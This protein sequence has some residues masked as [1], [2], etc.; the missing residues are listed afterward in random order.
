MDN[1]TIDNVGLGTNQFQFRPDPFGPLPFEGRFPDRPR[2]FIPWD[3]PV[4]PLRWP[5]AEV[6]ILVVE[7]G[8][9]YDEVQDFGLGIALKDAFDTTH[10]EHPSY[11]RFTFDKGHR[12]PG[13]GPA[14]GLSNVVFSDAFLSGYDQVWLFGVSSIQPYLSVTEIAA[15]DR[16]MRNGGGLLAMGDHEALGLGLCGAVPRVRTMRRWV[17]SGNQPDGRGPAPERNG[18]TR[19]DTLQPPAF[20]EGDTMPQPIRPAYRFAWPFWGTYWR[21]Q[22]YPHPLL[23]GPRGAIRV[24]P[25]HMHEGH[26]DPATTVD[27]AEYPGAERAQV[28]AWANSRV[29]PAGPREYA[30]LAAYD[31][32]AAGAAGGRVVVDATWHHWFNMNLFGLRSPAA[33]MT[34]RGIAYKDILAYFRNVAVWLSPPRQQ[35][36]MRRAGTLISLHL[37]GIVEEVLT[38]RDFDKA[39][40]YLLGIEARDALGRIAPQ[41]QSAAWFYDFVVERIPQGL[42]RFA[43]ELPVPDDEDDRPGL[44]GW[45]AFAADRVATTLFGGMVARIAIEANAM[46]E[47]G[48]EEALERLAEE[49]DALADEGAKRALKAAEDELAQTCRDLEKARSAFF[50]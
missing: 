26:C 19:H 28:V 9:S 5:K 30:V 31:G 34:A 18:G 50:G 12:T 45:G 48:G 25:D 10:P 39:S 24:L 11:A 42:R 7:D 46:R 36:A 43:P 20:G 1:E 47:G 2:P 49:I 22:R 37:P 38:I 33:D 23:C 44:S 29:G 8:A 13:T 14:N 17:F 35:V 27:P 4:W 40:L 3:R 16:W 21:R 15:L 6:K 41:C 32:H